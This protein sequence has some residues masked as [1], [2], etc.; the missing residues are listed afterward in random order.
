MARGTHVAPT[1]HL[2]TQDAETG[3]PTMSSEEEQGTL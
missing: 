1:Y 2:S 3:G